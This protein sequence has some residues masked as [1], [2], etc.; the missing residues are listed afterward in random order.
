MNELEK[1][2]SGDSA[3]APPAFILEGIPEEVA[4]RRIGLAPHTMFQ[5]LWHIT[6]WQQMSLDWVRG[7]ETPFP[8][9]AEAGFPSEADLSED[10]DQLR[11]RFFQGNDE[12]ASL[13]RDWL[14]SDPARLD[15]PIQCPSRPGTPTRTMTVREQLESLGAHNHYHFGRIVL[16]RQL[17][18][19]WPPPS[20]GYS[21]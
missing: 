8:E 17:L 2:L 21:W 19:A 11:A 1:V 13:V 12:A 14:A 18:G 10:W 4:H 9:H 7:I 3:A 16:L 5:E 15:A 6:F 20:G